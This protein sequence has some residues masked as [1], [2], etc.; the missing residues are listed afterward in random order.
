M[1]NP[2]HKLT[3]N[4]VHAQERAALK[5]AVRRYTFS[6]EYAKLQKLNKALPTRP[7]RQPTPPSF[8]APGWTI[9]QARGLHMRLADKLSSEVRC[10]CAIGSHL[11]T[12][13]P[14]STPVL[15]P[16][17]F[18]ILSRLPHEELTRYMQSSKYKTASPGR[19]PGPGSVSEL[20]PSPLIQALQAKNFP[21]WGFVLVRTYYASE[22]RWEAF[23]ARLDALCDEQLDQEAGEGLQGARESLE[24]K[25]I[26]DPRLAGIGHAEARS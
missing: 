10:F 15:P 22:P 1:I 9:E 7:E 18:D 8:V 4:A 5:Q 17:T 19:R 3:L 12:F 20:R 6:P 26:E 2:H 14:R 16:P 11:H 25:I 13:G 21:P 24:I 23:R